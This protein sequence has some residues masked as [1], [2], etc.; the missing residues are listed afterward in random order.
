MTPFLLT[1]ALL[2]QSPECINANGRRL[3]G[4]DCKNANDSEAACA[5]TPHGVCVAHVGRVV[6]FDPPL[7]LQAALAGPPPAPKCVTAGTQA[8]CGY[9]C[10]S[11]RGNVACA[12]TPAGV[13]KSQPDD[14]FICADPPP[15]VY[16]V[17]GSKTPAMSC[18]TRGLV[19]AC[20]YQCVDSGGAIGCTRTPFGVCDTQLGPPSCLD[21][22][23]YVI[24][25]GGK[26]TPK[27]TCTSHGGRLGCGYNCVTVGSA[28]ACSKTPK[29]S[30]D[31]QSGAPV[32]FDPPV[33][34]G[35]SRCLKVIGSE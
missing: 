13:C 12:Q 16:G 31:T 35:E 17:F 24:C 29:G 6:C 3:C 32:C 8:A 9:N 28:V 5:Q 18:I 10:V 33:R 2:A 1:A 27:P 23:K 14:A 22:D 34:G 20:G 7:W 21:P 25:A 4:Y 15:E 11:E 26:N 19:T 30:C